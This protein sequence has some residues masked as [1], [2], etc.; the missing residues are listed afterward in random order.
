[1]LIS[2]KSYKCIIQFC[3]VIIEFTIFVTC[4]KGDAQ[5]VHEPHFSRWFFNGLYQRNMGLAPKAKADK[6]W[7]WT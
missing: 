7:T 2:L 6:S 5:A 1:M 4:E 3:L